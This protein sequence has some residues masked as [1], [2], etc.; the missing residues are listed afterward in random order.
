MIFVVKKFLNEIK[1]FKY[2]CPLLV[3]V[4]IRTTF[5]Y[6]YPG[7]MLKPILVR[8]VYAIMFPHELFKVVLEGVVGNGFHGDIALDDISLQDGEEC[9]TIY[10]NG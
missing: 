2:S 5:V 1:T 6:D 8:L 7:D 9:Y 3:L 10:G 4:S